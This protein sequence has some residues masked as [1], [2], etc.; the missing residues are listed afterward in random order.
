MP[1]W[2][3]DRLHDP[4]ALGFLGGL[5]NVGAV[6]GVFA[7]AWLGPR[8]PRRSTFMV[9]YFLGGAPVFFAFAIFNVLPPVLVVTALAG[10]AG[11]VINPIIGAVEYERIPES[12]QARVL[13][14]VKA[15]AWVGIPFGSLLGG[16]LTA[17]VGLTVALVV[18]GIAM[19]L[20]TLAPFVFP[21]WQQLGAPAP[22]PA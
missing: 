7:A 21:T 4:T 13:G 14:A 5:S 18:T 10:L 19:L 8:I 1:V 16:G 9:G 6:V 17:S 15:S 2:V 3:K 12:L 11:G 22:Q 20:A